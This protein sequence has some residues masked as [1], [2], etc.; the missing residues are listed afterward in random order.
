MVGKRGV[1]FFKLIAVAC[2]ALCCAFGPAQASK[3]IA[4][5][6]GNGA[7]RYA[8]RL[9][10]P[11]GD[12]K[13]MRDV[14]TKL[15]FEV[16]YGE[17]LDLKELR[18]IV[19]RFGSRLDDA[20]VA[21]VYFAGH[22]ATFDSIPYVVPVDAEF[23][24]LSEMPAELVA[25]EELI[26]DLRKAKTVRMAILDACRDN[27]AEQALKRSRGA[28]SRGLAP[29]RNASGLI[30]AYATQSGSTAAD[31]AG[32][33]GGWWSSGGTIHS[34]FTAALLKNIGTPGVDVKD[35]FYKVG[36]DVI[37]STGERQRPEI[38]VSMYDQ[39]V[40]VP[41][42]V[43]PVSPAPAVDAAAQAWEAVKNTTSLA[44]LDAFIGQ[45]SDSPVFVALARER[46]EQLARSQIAVANPP[47]PQRKDPPGPL[48]THGDVCVMYHSEITCG[49][50]DPSVP[51]D[52]VPDGMVC[53]R[54]AGGPICGEPVFAGKVLPEGDL[55]AGYRNQDFGHNQGI[56][57]KTCS[58]GTPAYWFFH[59][60]EGSLTWE[61][62]KDNSCPPLR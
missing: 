61:C 39:Y 19:A 23:A 3:R 6:V 20:D 38:S 5:V 58:R 56:A 57:A 29:I 35:M 49:T 54:R 22:G 50:P 59:T 16:I 40:L 60:K 62:R 13:S 30:I 41:G 24:N 48:P 12:A 46:R 25:V 8:H 9:D 14:L 11:V 7:Y 47:G 2:L 52:Q 31:A 37:A 15:G 45:F 17:D 36:R 21:L 26:G 10:N 43:A 53:L 28:P 51:D 18:R 34:P 55:C 32:S 4:L 1:R 44:A 33:S 42:S 27:A